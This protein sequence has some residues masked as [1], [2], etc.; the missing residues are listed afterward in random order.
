M[1][2]HATMLLQFTMDFVAEHTQEMEL[3]A[4]NFAKSVT[5]SRLVLVALQ[6]RLQGFFL[7]CVENSCCSTQCS[8]TV[9]G[10]DST[11]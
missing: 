9:H 5:L 4:A 10:L 11:R 8:V 2:R 3:V 7:H 6:R 1:H